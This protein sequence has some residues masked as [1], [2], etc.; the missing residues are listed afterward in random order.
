ML[1]VSRTPTNAFPETRVQEVDQASCPLTPT[2]TR[3]Q[4]PIAA[5]FPLEENRRFTGQPIEATS[6]RSY[7]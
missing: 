6:N 4:F 3:P 7:H 1:S 5:L 2:T